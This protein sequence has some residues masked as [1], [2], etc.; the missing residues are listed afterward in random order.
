MATKVF[1]K[2]C[3]AV[4]H[5]GHS[6]GARG[7]EG[8][9]ER[10]Q[11]AGGGHAYGGRTSLG[12]KDGPP[13]PCPCPHFPQGKTGRPARRRTLKA[14]SG[15]P[16]AAAH[17]SID[18]GA[19]PPPAASRSLAASS[20]RRSWRSRA[21]SSATGGGTGGRSFGGFMCD[22]A[23]GR[24]APPA[25]RPVASSLMR[26]CALRCTSRSTGAAAPEWGAAAAAEDGDAPWPF[27]LTPACA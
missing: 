2:Y 4:T 26:R 24:R 19:P 11:I 6:Q 12:K 18:G 9:H 21:C 1:F 8:R 22:P 27:P 3:L 17:A 7:A 13:P 5:S 15:R 16:T 10:D 20:L 23:F 14:G 25:A